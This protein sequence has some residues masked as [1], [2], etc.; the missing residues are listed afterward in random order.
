M[1]NAA[2]LTYP[3]GGM[4][5]RHANAQAMI[6][7]PL[8]KH[9]VFKRN[10]GNNA[11]VAA[12][13]VTIGGQPVHD[14]CEI[15]AFDSG[16][17]LVGVGTVIRGT[18]VFSVWGDNTQTEEKDGCGHSEKIS[19][20]LWDGRKEYPLDFQSGSDLRYSAN[21]IF[22]GTFTVPDG[23]LITRFALSKVYPNPFRGSIKIAFDV[24]TIHG[25]DEHAV[26][27]NLYDM[28]G[29][30]VCRLAKGKFKAGHHFLSWNGTAEND[31]RRL[32]ASNVYII[33]MRAGNF[34]KRVKVIRIR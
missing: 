16:G 13:R 15:G 4:G 29:S 19:F 27:I 10:T 8:P 33:Q 32:N 7:L 26:E 28:K 34:S 31:E 12:S 14:S 24:P 6:Q 18:T 30:L 5:K 20:K 9:Y 21:G 17:E 2:T 23:F 11:S 1:K 3:A 25:I 22:L